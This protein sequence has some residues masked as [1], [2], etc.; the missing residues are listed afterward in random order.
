M[1]SQ[2]AIHLAAQRF[3]KSNP[4]SVR[5]LP[6]PTRFST[7]LKAERLQAETEPKRV[8]LL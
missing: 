5:R 8:I 7:W 2:A 6:E 4:I 1:K 3:E